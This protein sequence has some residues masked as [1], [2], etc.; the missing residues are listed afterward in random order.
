SIFI[1]YSI[2]MLFFAPPSN[3]AHLFIIASSLMVY[4]GVLDDKYDLSVRS[5]LIGQFI[6][7]SFL[8]YGLGFYIENL[9]NLFTLGDVHLGGAG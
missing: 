4:I 2:S 8:I 5:R 1:S 3:G 6:I 7:S 9:G